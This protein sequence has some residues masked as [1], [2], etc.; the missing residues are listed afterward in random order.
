[1]SVQVKNNAIND[2]GFNPPR[3]IR[4]ENYEDFCDNIKASG[5][6]FSKLYPEMNPTSS[7]RS[8]YNT[9]KPVTR[10]AQ[11]KQIK[12]YKK[13]L[14]KKL[15]MRDWRQEISKQT[16]KPNLKSSKKVEK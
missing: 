16:S 4:E 10:G 12:T 7:G 9:R 8:L 6:K 14:D 13:S 11:Q 15:S 1:M 5:L 2:I 3:T